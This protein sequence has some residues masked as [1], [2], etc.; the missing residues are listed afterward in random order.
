[1]VATTR[2]RAPTCPVQ[3]LRGPKPHVVVVPRNW[4]Q[5]ARRR[6]GGKQQ[7][8]QQQQQRSAAN[9]LVIRL[10]PLS[11]P[12]DI[13]AAP[14]SLQDASALDALATGNAATS[15][16]CFLSP[17]RIGIQALFEPSF[18]PSWTVQI[19][20]R[21]FCLPCRQLP[22]AKLPRQPLWLLRSCRH[23]YRGRHHWRRHF[24]KSPAFGPWI[25]DGRRAVEG[26][27]M[28]Q[29]WLMGCAALFV[30][31]CNSAE[32]ALTQLSE[33]SIATTSWRFL[34]AVTA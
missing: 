10:V 12:K 21:A 26:A 30:L 33:E 15:A 16:S 17:L 8:Q 14:V 1:M 20:L 2:Q 24:V 19:P 31:A 23:R 27:G 11:A 7:Q 32:N 6:R 9:A 28:V 18:R 29:F 25:L 34:V 13:P 5:P 4:L 22:A 3:I